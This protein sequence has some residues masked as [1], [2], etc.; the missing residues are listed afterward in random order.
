MTDLDIKVFV[1]LAGLLTL[2]AAVLCG[3]ALRFMRGMERGREELRGIAGRLLQECLP[4]LRDLRMGASQLLA[5]GD[6]ARQGAQ[7]F[8]DLGG[9]VGR[10][11]SAL[12][13]ALTFFGR[14]PAPPRD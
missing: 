9:Q 11:A 12:R 7:G 2:C 6:L 8:V 10:A 3:Y 13:A 14:G 5:A 4:I 1:L